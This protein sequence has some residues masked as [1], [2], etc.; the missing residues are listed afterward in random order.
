MAKW[1]DEVFA[2]QQPDE[3]KIVCKD[4]V[5]RENDRKLGNSEIKGCTLGI[6]QVYSMNNP[7]PHDV[8]FKNK[9]CGYYVSEN[10]E[11]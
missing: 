1:D 10:D 7:K 3:N 11:D 2:L 8:L 6:C 4:C 5:F 9:P